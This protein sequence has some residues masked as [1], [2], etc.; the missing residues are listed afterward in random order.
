MRL[1]QANL[2]MVFD[3]YGSPLI[4]SGKKPS[5]ILT[6]AN[7]VYTTVVAGVVGAIVE[8]ERF[9]AVADRLCTC[10]PSKQGLII[11]KWV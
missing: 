11:R 5:L 4:E 6:L 2:V 8:S 7:V 1:K 3:L 10:L 9:A